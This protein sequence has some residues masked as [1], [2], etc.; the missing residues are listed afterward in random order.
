M[1]RNFLAGS[2]GDAA[3]AVLAAVSYNFRRLLAWLSG[4]LRAFAMALMV[5]PTNSIPI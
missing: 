5:M 4:L 3:N 1:N 2:N